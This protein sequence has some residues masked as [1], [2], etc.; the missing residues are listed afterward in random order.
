MGCTEYHA[1]EVKFLLAFIYCAYDNYMNIIFDPDKD[2]INQHKHGYSLADAC[3]LDWENMVIFEDDR[4]DYGE[5]RYVGLTYG[6][7]YLNNR[8]FSVCFTESDDFA[9]CRVIS[10]RLATKQEMRRYAEA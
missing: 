6:L 9:V 7:A 3:R 5:V 8:I 10:L 2:V 1:G 4:F